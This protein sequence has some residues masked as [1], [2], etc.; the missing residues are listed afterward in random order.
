[1]DEVSI[2][3][4]L[5]NVNLEEEQDEPQEI[6][7]AQDPSRAMPIP[8]PVLVAG[9][10]G[11]RCLYHVLADENAEAL[12]VLLTREVPVLMQQRQQTIELVNQLN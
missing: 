9:N 10:G 4:A 6:L 1:M 3:I 2:P 12:N 8:I 11:E 5:N 7:P